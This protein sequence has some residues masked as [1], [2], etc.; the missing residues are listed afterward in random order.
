[1]KTNS[2]KLALI[3]F[4]S[5]LSATES[6]FIPLMY[7][8]YR[9]HNFFPSR[10]FCFHF[11]MRLL[12]N[13]AVDLKDFTFIFTSLFEVLINDDDWLVLLKMVNFLTL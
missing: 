9:P 8:I 1:M 4:T 5:S 13:A 11:R 6:S 7:L 2:L 3:I 10:F 12:L